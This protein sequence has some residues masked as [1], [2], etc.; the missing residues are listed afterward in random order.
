M[1]EALHDAPAVDHEIMRRALAL[2]ERGRGHTSPNPM[3]GAVIV[4]ADGVIVGSGYHE[5]AGE[6][7]AEI[8]ALRRAGVAARGA[9]LY[10]SLEPCCHTGRTGPCVSAIAQAGVAR[11]VAAVEDPNPKVAGGG[12]RYLR[13]RGIEVTVGPRAAEAR[14]LNAVFETNMRQGRPFVTVKT[15]MSL[16]G[17]VAAAV[18]ERTQLTSSEAARHAQRVRAEVDA[19]G[20]GSETVLVDDPLLTARDVYRERKL[21]RVVFDTRLRMPLAA[22]LWRTLDAGPLIIVT[23]DQACE[24]QPEHVVAL[25]AAGARLL[26]SA[27]DDLPGSLRMLWREG[28][29]SL[30]VEGGPRLQAAMWSAGCV[31]R[32]R[33]YVAP[34]VV[35]EAGVAWAM[36]ASCSLGALASVHAE[37]LGVDVLL[38]G[39]VHRAD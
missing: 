26:A 11:V 18:G 17:K 8:K 33:C 9:T 35:G 6:P 29:A 27:R 30:L 24:A 12:V 37:V 34:V 15:A 4:S 19:I 31:D 7:H 13:E 14:R 25:G 23:T 10:C 38:E 2:A 21:T 3:V 39:D 1:G 16:D 20:V 22:R 36:P 28:I 32:M 5:G